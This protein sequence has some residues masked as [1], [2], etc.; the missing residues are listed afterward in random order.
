M[1][2]TKTQKKFRKEMAQAAKDFEKIYDNPYDQPYVRK[3]K[4]SGGGWIFSVIFIAF[5]AFVIILG[6]KN[7]GESP[8]TDIRELGAIAASSRYSAPTS[9]Q[10]Q[11]SV[12]YKNEV[13]SKPQTGVMSRSEAEILNQIDSATYPV[14][15]Y[16]EAINE[17]NQNSLIIPLQGNEE[18]RLTLVGGIEACQQAKE[19]ITAINCPEQFADLKLIK[20][21]AIGYIQQSY[22]FL[23]EYIATGDSSLISQSNKSNQLASEKNRQYIFELEEYLKT[24][25]YRY[26]IEGNSIR[27]WYNSSY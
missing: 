13:N 2:L 15:L 25:G 21:E 9:D 19:T 4:S 17:W 7:S 12:I 20:I 18:Y 27:Y 16:I 10:P 1:K 22:S 11:T 5:I 26:S 6:S 3:K 23:L 24:N 8:P 14:E